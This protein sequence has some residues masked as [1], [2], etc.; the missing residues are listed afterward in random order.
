MEHVLYLLIGLLRPDIRIT[1]GTG[2]V[3]QNPVGMTF[4]EKAGCIF[5]RVIWQLRY[6]AAEFLLHTPAAKLDGDENSLKMVST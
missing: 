4:F 5:V 3:L 2:A 1:T 6:Y